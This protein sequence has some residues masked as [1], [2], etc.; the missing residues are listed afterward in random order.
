MD[1]VIG[2]D[3]V[4]RR[5]ERDFKENILAIENVTIYSACVSNDIES[6]YV[7]TCLLTLNFIARTRIM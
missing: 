6:Q 1:M 4:L 5:K 7:L 2:L 3:W